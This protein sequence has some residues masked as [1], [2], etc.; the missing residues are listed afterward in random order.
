MKIKVQ[1]KKKYI[2]ED[3]LLG[4]KKRIVQLPRQLNRRE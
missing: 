2:K 3:F 4:R 1:E